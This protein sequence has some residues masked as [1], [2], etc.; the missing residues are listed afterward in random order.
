MIKYTVMTQDITKVPAGSTATSTYDS[1]S[2]FSANGEA[3]AAGIKTDAVYGLYKSAYKL[4]VSSISSSATEALTSDEIKE[5]KSQINS[6]DYTEIEKNLIEEGTY[7]FEDIKVG[8]EITTV[9]KIIKTEGTYQF[10][11]SPFGNPNKFSGVFCNLTVPTLNNITIKDKLDD[12]T[13]IS[14]DEIS[15]LFQ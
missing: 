8:D 4:N 13:S 9:N 7:T 10:Y 6:I 14:K 12:I 1:T 5:L 15:I 2:T 3:I 11:L